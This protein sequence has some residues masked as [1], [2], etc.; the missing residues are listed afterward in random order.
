M[1][2]LNVM[3][4]LEWKNEKKTILDEYGT[5]IVRYAETWADMM[6]ER[7]DNGEKLEDIAQETSHRA[8]VNRITGNMYGIA[9][10]LLS[11][12][13][14]HG[15]RLRVWHNGKYGVPPEKEGVVNPAIITLPEGMSV[16]DLVEKL[17]DNGYVTTEIMTKDDL[18]RLKNGVL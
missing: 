1:R 5:E 2:F 14:V 16:D 9:V 8:D 15:E 13:W 4:Q 12:A 18:E 7:M 6:E 11:A 17:K 10:R 3:L